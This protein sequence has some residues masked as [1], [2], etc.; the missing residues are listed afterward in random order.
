MQETWVWSLGWEDPLEKGKAT[1]SSTV[2]WRIPW[3]VEPGRLQSMGLQR[4]GHDWVTNA[5]PFFSTRTHRLIKMSVSCC[6]FIG[7]LYIFWK[8]TVYQIMWFTSISSSSAGCLSTSL[9]V[10]FV[11]WSFSVRWNLTRRILLL[12]LVPLCQTHEF[13]VKV[14]VMRISPY[15]FL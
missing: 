5:S 10:S 6:G 15:I 13:I 2:A 1:H 14:N 12:L 7:V 8:S 11:H 3:T 9:I 4:V